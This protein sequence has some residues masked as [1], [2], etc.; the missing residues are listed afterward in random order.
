MKPWSQRPSEIAN[1]LNPAFCGWLLREATEGYCSVTPAGIPFPLVFL[2]LPVVLHRPTRALLPRSTVTALRP[3]LRAH[4]E[5]RIGLA[6]RAAELAEITRDAVLFLTSHRLVSV[7]DAGT[8]T[9]IGRM[10]RG[11]AP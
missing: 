5:A 10:G 3:W 4:P 8:L 6:E 7:T 9:P 2:I 1:N 11:K